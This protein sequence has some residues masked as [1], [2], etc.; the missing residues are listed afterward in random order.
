MSQTLTAKVKT[1][2]TGSGDLWDEIAL[3]IYGDEHAMN[4]L[5]DANYPYRFIDLFPQGIILIV[6]QTLIL[7]NNLKHISKIPD[8]AKLLPWR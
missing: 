8:I 3:T 4:A 6:P 1:Y 7:T 5:Q 2:V